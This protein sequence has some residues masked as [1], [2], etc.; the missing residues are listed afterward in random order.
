MRT[1]EI[2]RKTNETD[3]R[4]SLKARLILSAWRGS[5]LAALLKFFHRSA[6]HP[7]FRFSF[8]GVQ[9]PCACVHNTLWYAGPKNQNNKK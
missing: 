2:T 8:P 3:I 4:L 9:L 6:T 1:A 5:R 7:F